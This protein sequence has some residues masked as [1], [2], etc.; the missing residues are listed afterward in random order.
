MAILF[1]QE[2]VQRQ[3]SWIQTCERNQRSSYYGENA[4]EVRQAD[5]NELVRWETRVAALN[6]DE[7]A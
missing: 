5:R 4:Q 2:Q 1:A 6:D 7:V 3:R